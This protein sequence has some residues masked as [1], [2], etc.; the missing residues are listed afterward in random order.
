MHVEYLILLPDAAEFALWLRGQRK[1]VPERTSHRARSSNMA[2]AAWAASRSPTAQNIVDL[3]LFLLASA[4][5]GIRSYG[6]RAIAGALCAP[7]VS[8][9]QL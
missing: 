4:S 8:T 6:A 3:L 7:A 9:A 5:S 1:G 2:Q